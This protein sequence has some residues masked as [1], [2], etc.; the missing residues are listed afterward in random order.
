MS[1]LS[2]FRTILKKCLSEKPKKNVL[3]HFVDFTAI[4]IS[5]MHVL[6]SMTC[7]ETFVSPERIG[8]TC[9]YLECIW[10]LKIPC[11]Y[12]WN[13]FLTLFVNSIY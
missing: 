9:K 2:C 4:L 5:A 6:L 10:K 13:V 3:E 12:D 1:L 7:R 8:W 11:K